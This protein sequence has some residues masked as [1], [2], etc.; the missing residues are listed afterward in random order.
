MSLLIVHP[1]GDALAL[2]NIALTLDPE[3]DVRV[4]PD[5]GDPLDIIAAASWRH[6]RGLFAT[7]PHLRMIAS[8]G[9]GADQLLAD[10]TIGADIV[11][12]RVLDPSTARTVAEFALLAVLAHQR[13]WNRLAVARSRREWIAPNVRAVGRVLVLG[14]GRIGRR[15]AR[16]FRDAGF[17]VSAWSRTE[18][19][20][21]GVICDHGPEALPPLLQTA[22][23]VICAL[24]LTPETAGILSRNLFDSLPDGAYVV[25][26]GRGEHLVEADLLD[27]LRSGK[28]SGATLDVF[29]EEPL[30]PSSAL[31]ADERI[32]IT[33]HVAAVP[34]REAIVEQIVMNYRAIINGRSVSGV[35]DR[36]RGY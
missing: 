32:T 30:P 6:P 9:A 22:D 16:L 28:L 25:N 18:R 14:L 15:T 7:F 26:A 1:E 8:L 3:L 33:P 2:R 36:G 20:I 10:D 12:T 5:A 34:D 13:D 23:A 35:V 24:P 11:L 31:W 27:A 21:E 17:Q 29:S 4:W 19:A